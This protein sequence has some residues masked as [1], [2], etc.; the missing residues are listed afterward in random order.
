M[1]QRQKLE[2]QINTPTEVTLLYDEPV[3]GQSQY[4]T[5]NLYAVAANGM[6]YSFFAPDTVHEQLK[7]LCLGQSAII[8][9]LAAQRGNKI[10]TAYDVV[11]PKKVETVPANN[12]IR[13]YVELDN[14]QP[15]SKGNIGADLHP[16]YNIMLE[17]LRDAVSIAKQL[18]SVI[19]ANRIGIT[20]FIARSKSNSYGG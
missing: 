16:T 15:V 9:K 20:L 1:T 18:D 8:T 12:N 11:L 19:D 17:S 14:Q 2:L 5:Y 7:N 10:V 4:G 3:T 6:E 13:P